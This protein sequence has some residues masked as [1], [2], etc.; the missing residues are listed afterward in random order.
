MQDFPIAGVDFPEAQRLADLAS[1]S[2][3]LKAAIDTCSRLAEL[4]REDSKDGVLIDSLWTTALIRYARCFASGK[5][6]GLGEEILADLPGDPIGAHRWYKNLRDKHIAHSVNPFENVLVGAVLAPQD[7]AEKGV[8][9]VSILVGRHMVAD[10]AG[11][12]QL[13]RLCTILGRKIAELIKDSK[14]KVLQIA[15][16]MPIDEIYSRPRPIFSAPSP[17]NAAGARRSTASNTAPQTDGREGA[18]SGQPSPAPAV[19]HER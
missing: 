13:G 9:G 3:D 16:A 12:E 2:Q 4:L 11:V 7:S 19:G 14:E 18:S 15:K 1:I 5:R 6:Y 17:N 8:I 10:I